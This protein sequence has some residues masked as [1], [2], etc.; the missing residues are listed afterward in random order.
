MTPQRLVNT[1]QRA[2]YTAIV[3]AA[4]MIGSFGFAG[5]SFYL[6]RKATCDRRNVSLNVLRD[7]IMLAQPTEAEL[8]EMPP[9][10]RDR[11]HRF[12]ASAFRRIDEARC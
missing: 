1:P 4:L 3:C 10:R 2:L 5:Y 8:A 6:A 9:D 7:V 12:F 11:Q